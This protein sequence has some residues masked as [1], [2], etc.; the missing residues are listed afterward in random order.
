MTPANIPTNPNGRCFLSYRRSHLEEVQRLACMLQR[1][2]IPTWQDIHN[3]GSEP[4]IDGL[5]AALRDPHTASAVMWITRDMR[6]SAVIREHELTPIIKRAREDKSFHA[7][8]VLADGLDYNDRDELPQPVGFLE[9]ISSTWN[10][11]KV[12]TTPASAADL[13]KVSEAVLHQRLKAIHQATP[14]GQDIR[15]RIAAF[16]DAEAGEDL[17]AALSINWCDLF[18]HRH[19]SEMQWKTDIL[20]TLA[21][22]QKAIRK[23]VPGRSLTLEGKLPLSVAA[24]WGRSFMQTGG[25]DIGFL[26]QPANERWSIRAQREPC[27]LDRRIEQHTPGLPDVAV[28]VSLEQCLASAVQDSADAPQRWAGVVQIEPKPGRGP[29]RLNT[30]GQAFDAALIV[31]QALIDCVERFPSAARFH[32]FMRV[33]VGLAFLIGQ[34]LNAVGP[35]QMYEHDQTLNVR[36]MYR[37]SVLLSETPC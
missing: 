19:A 11:L 6:A 25:I 1:H 21:R 15:I 35:V 7:H 12:S 2:G 36:G 32:L 16:Q 34:S 31:R 33:P 26:Q 24:A 20:P 3:L 8:M 23:C 10:L 28:L 14:V 17:M 29:V 9:D 37:R 5:N 22:V 18:T 13:V 27:G 30:P 4:T